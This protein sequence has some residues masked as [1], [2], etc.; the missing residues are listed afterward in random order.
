MVSSHTD[1]INFSTPG[2]KTIDCV[3]CVCLGPSAIRSP[4]RPL[5]LYRN[6]IKLLLRVHLCAW[7][8]GRSNFL[9]IIALIILFKLSF[10][11]VPHRG[12][13]RISIVR[14]GYLADQAVVLSPVEDTRQ[15]TV[16]P[17]L[18]GLSL[19][20]ANSHTSLS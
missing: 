8:L 2:K 16:P 17:N 19:G 14:P 11:H 9:P 4:A 7:Q 15:P 1:S 10:I 20:L 18:L 13:A 12:N 6:P 3:V 5:F